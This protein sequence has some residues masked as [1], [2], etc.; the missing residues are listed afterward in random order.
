M[1]L[2]FDIVN[3]VRRLDLKGD[4]LAGKAVTKTVSE[5]LKRTELEC[6]DQRM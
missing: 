5:S 3:S 6:E 4:G 1:D 2:G